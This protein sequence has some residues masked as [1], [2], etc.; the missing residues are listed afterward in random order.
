MMTRITKMRELRTMVTF[1]VN[2][3][4]PS[5]EPPLTERW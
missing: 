3:S 4:P 1:L 2:E 5:Y